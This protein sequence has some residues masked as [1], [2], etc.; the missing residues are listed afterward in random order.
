MTLSD[1]ARAARRVARGQAVRASRPSRKAEAAART[2]GQKAADRE[3]RVAYLA[4]RAA[5]RLPLF[6]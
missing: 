1:F 4:Q 5:Q 3:A 6:S 2:A